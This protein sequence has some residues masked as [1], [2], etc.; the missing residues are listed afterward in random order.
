MS[1]HANDAI[2]DYS[3][4]R[5]V[6]LSGTLRLSGS[7]TWILGLQGALRQL[8]CPVLHIVAG[9]RSL[10]PVPPQYNICYT[11]RARSDPLLRLARV[12]QLHKL[13][14]RWFEQHSDRVLSKRIASVLEQRGWEDHLDLVIKDFTS[15]CPSYFDPYKVLSVIHQ[16]L[17]PGWQD[18]KLHRQA[19]RDDMLAAVCATVAQEVGKLGLQVPHVLYN[20]LDSEQVRQ[21]STAF[22]VAEDFILFVGSLS[23]G[24]GVY[25]LLDAYVMADLA[26]PLW[27]VGSGQ[28]KAGLE[29]RARELGLVGRV[30]LLGYQPNPY[31][32]IARAKL[33]V[34]PS[35][36]E[37]RG[38]AEA[39]PYVCLEAAVLGT[40]FLVSDYAAAAEF[41]EP[42]VRVAY[43]PEAGFTRRLADAMRNAI[44]HPAAPGMLP[45]VLNKV[46]PEVAARAYL[47][48]VD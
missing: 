7:T 27:L 5:I 6:L 43:E 33:L 38:W 15:A 35:R 19:Q 10:V 20:P 22:T 2:A 41:Y 8:G 44:E 40:Q 31:P 39:T 26:L 25:E 30:K 16:M 28:E 42:R 37:Y 21:Q 24:K 36:S 46:A 1:E 12:V 4:M 45:G 17:S 23:K 13:F 14:P 48:L 18:S 29:A 11:G 34:L 9:E 32:Y 47:E 3:Q